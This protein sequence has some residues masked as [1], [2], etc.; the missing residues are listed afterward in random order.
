[1]KGLAQGGHHI[2]GILDQIVVLGAGA[3]D[4]NDVH[5]LEGIVTD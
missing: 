1:M 4:T 3:G 5:L 2:F